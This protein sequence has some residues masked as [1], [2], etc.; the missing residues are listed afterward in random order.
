MSPR[1]YRS[2]RRATAAEATRERIVAAAVRV[3]GAS[4][5]ESAFSLES[6]ATTAGVTRLT[7]YNQFGSRRALLESAF[8]R[9]AEEGGLFRIGEVM[10]G[11]DAAAGLTQIIRVFC[12]FWSRHASASRHLLDA[13]VHDQELRDSLNAR[14]ERRRQIMS[15]LV[16]RM[17]ER[18]E[19]APNAVRDVVDVLFVLTSVEV[20][21][22]LKVGKRSTAAVCRLIQELAADVIAR[23]GAAR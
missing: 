16:G 23:G 2:A 11:P 10:A 12:D 7:V 4:G 19:V 5:D 15:R 17:A 8:D 21:L 22:A 18:G 9:L 1:P 13:A 14:Q 6:V 20:F 3:L